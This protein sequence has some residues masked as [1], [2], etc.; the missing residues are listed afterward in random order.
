MRTYLAGGCP[1][2]DGRL[3]HCIQETTLGSGRTIVVTTVNFWY[4]T[5]NDL[6]DETLRATCIPMYTADTDAGA[7]PS[8]SVGTWCPGGLP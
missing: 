5:G 4:S 2:D 7:S 8:S 3:G 6:V 1:L